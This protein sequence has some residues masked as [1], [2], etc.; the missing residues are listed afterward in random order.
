MMKRRM[1]LLP[2]LVLLLWCVGR[3]GDKPICS[4]PTGPSQSA[5]GP[6]PTLVRFGD[7]KRLDQRV[8]LTTWA[9]PVEEVLA[10]LSAESGVSLRCEG[11]EVAD[12]R[13]SVVLREQP[14]RRVQA[15]LAETLGL[16]WRRERKAPEY[17]YLLF[18]DVKSRQ[19][20]ERLLG[21]SRKQYEQGLRRLVDSLKLT[22]EEVAAR[23]ERDPMWCWWLDEPQRRRAIGFLRALS[24]VQWDQLM[25]TGH[26]E[27]HFEGLAP[28]EQQEV[29]QYVE[30]ANRRRDAR[31]EREGTQGRRRIG[32]V[33]RPGGKIA[34][35][36]YGGVPPGPD[37]SLDF[38]VEPSW[39]GQHGG[40]GLY[41]A[42]TKEELQLLR[43]ELV[44]PQFQR[45][46]RLTA[47]T[48][49]R[50][51]TLRWKEKPQRWEQVLRTLVGDADVQVVSDSFLYHPWEE[52]MGLPEASAL[53]DRPLGEVL[54]RVTAPFF[55]LWRR[56]GEVLLFRNRNWFLEKR[57]DVP[58]RDL[59]RWRKHLTEG[60]RLELEDLSE[61][62]LL[63][64]RQL[65][66]V[67]GV[68]IPT[69]TARAH[70]EVLAFYA[71]LSRFQREQLAQSGLQIRE[72]EP[73]QAARLG[74]WRPSRAA[75]ADGRLRL[76]REPT[77]VVFRLEADASEAREERVTLGVRGPRSRT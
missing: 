14:L 63:T 42:Y 50:R 64:H 29:L 13:V 62:A 3:A 25:Q 30:E 72:L 17:R 67:E 36:V 59:R 10:R 15:L 52:N 46:R 66:N 18:Q 55:Y 32:D 75:G 48:D 23:R 26:L 1:P 6:S 35:D 49:Q 28:R 40:D 77:A 12:Q 9:E 22:P 70:R 4:A 38:G 60:G 7:D 45:G 31:D 19:E 76:R 69:D 21:R 58:E 20:E 27:I 68:D 73:A 24:A 41:L 39:G 44:P 54:D 65:R 5:P 51:V 56:E 74:T 8:S 71:S 37:S 57:H 11:R 53:Q 33:T 2:F 61:L 43:E 34:F 47:S 16:Y